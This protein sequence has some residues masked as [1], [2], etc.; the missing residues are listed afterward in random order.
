MSP[1]FLLV[2]LLVVQTAFSMPRNPFQPL[3]SPCDVLLKQLAQ[4]TLHG[5][6]SSDK[7]AIGVMRDAQKKWRR[8]TSGMEIAPG[9]R[10]LDISQQRLS[11]TVP[12]ECGQSFYSWKMEGK[13]Y[14][15]DAYVRSAN[16]LVLSKPRG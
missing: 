12:S 2:L 4:W 10:V 6:I 14:G 16:S 1:N 9:V 13:K 11:V 15:M 3:L 7:G 5:V 8:I